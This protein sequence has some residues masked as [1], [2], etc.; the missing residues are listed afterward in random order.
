MDKIA[1]W[2]KYF[3]FDDCQVQILKFE[4]ELLA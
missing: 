1:K 2:R 3:V 4:T